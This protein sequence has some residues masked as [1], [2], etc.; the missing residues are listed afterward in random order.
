MKKKPIDRLQARLKEI[1]AA[2]DATSVLQ[3]VEI[4]YRIEVLQCLQTLLKSVP[5]DSE[6]MKAAAGHYRVLD[7]FIT[8]LPGDRQYPLKYEEAQI[9]DRAAALISF[10]T[11]LGGIRKR[12]KSFQKGDVY[13]EVVRQFIHQAY[14]VWYQYRQTFVEIE[15]EENINEQSK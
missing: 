14:I 7:A 1:A 8:S 6:N 12:F 13:K 10:D 11:M 15:L 4:Q 3:S 2:K 5:E 9:K